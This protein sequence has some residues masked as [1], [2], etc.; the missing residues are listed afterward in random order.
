MSVRTYLPKLL[1]ILRLLCGY[2]SRYRERIETFIGPENVAALDAVVA[3]CEAM[4]AILVVLVP[5]GT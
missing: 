4:E 3:A 1:L 2:I 5:S